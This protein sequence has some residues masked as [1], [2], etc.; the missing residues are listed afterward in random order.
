MMPAFLLLI[1]LLL[2]VMQYKQL[3]SFVSE[4]SMPISAVPASIEAQEAVLAKVRG[5]I[6]DTA[7]DTLSIS[8]DE[9]NHLIRTSRSLNELKLDYHLELEDTLLVARNSLP[10]TS[11]HGL[12]ALLAKVTGIRGYLN[13]VMKGYPELKEGR[14]T[15]VPVSAVMNGVPAPASVLTSKGMLDIREWVADKAIYDQA[16]AVL[17]EV[18]IR[19][20]LLLLIKRS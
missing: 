7:A 14:I 6:A 2:L 10:V 4:K 5:F 8:S 19:A 20:G 15:M 9:V 18:K 3:R 13:S 16:M 17:A 1:V 12:P 11:M